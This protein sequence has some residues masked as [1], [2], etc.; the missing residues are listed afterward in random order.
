MPEDMYWRVEPD[1]PRDTRPPD[2]YDVIDDSTHPAAWPLGN[3]TFEAATAVAEAHNDIVKRLEP[4]RVLAMCK[5]FVHSGDMTPYAQ[6]KFEQLLA[7]QQ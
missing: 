6:I 5:L 3:L 7:G 1:Q 2:T 4:E